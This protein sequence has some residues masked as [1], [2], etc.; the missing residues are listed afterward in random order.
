M[1]GQDKQREAIS[2]L[3]FRIRED[4]KSDNIIKS[5]EIICPECKENIFIELKDFKINLT[6]CKNGHI[7]NN[8]SFEDY[9]NVQVLDISTIKCDSCKI[10]NKGIIHNYEF[11]KCISC[12]INLCPDCKRKHDQHHKI[13]DYDKKNY[14]CNIHKKNFVNYC[15]NCKENIC[16]SCEPSHK[17]HKLIYF[18]HILPDDNMMNK[19]DELKENIDSINMIIDDFI[20]KM[21]NVKKSFEIYYNTFSNLIHIYNNN[22]NCNYQLIKNINEFINNNKN[23]IDNI[24][25]IKHSVINEEPAKLMKIY[26]KMNKSK[27]NILNNVNNNIRIIDVNDEKYNL[28]PNLES[29]FNIVIDNGSSSIKFGITG[30]NIFSKISTCI[31][32]SNNNNDNLDDNHFE[33]YIGE[34]MEIT[35]EH[36]SLNYP[37]DRG[38]IKYWNILEKLYDHIFYNELKVNTSEHNILITELPFNSNKNRENLT[39]FMFEVYDVPGFYIMNQ[40]ALSLLAEGKSTGLVVDLGDSYNHIYPM[41]NYGCDKN[42]KWTKT[43]GKDITEFL[44]KSLK[45]NNQNIKYL[46][47]AK[48]IKEKCC[49]VAY[50]YDEEI[51]SVESDE[52]K[53]PDSTSITIK[54]L[55]IKCPELLFTSDVNDNDNIAKICNDIIQSSKEDMRRDLYKTIIL[56]GGNSMFPGLKERLTKEIKN[57]APYDYQEDIKV[58][59]SPERIYHSQIGGQILASISTFERKWI[60]KLEYEEEGKGIIHKKCPNI[61]NSF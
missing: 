36:L 8:L 38:I 16:L 60:T 58:L 61:P 11:Y 13:I 3:V 32:Y 52:Y 12:K 43:G 57:F 5:K 18:G 30:E 6:G 46:E 53:L 26:Y 59:A 4:M 24:N 47:H 33:Y 19:L 50:D 37:I 54:D 40:S 39:E 56:A 42:V 15:E 29:E 49:Y 34:K 21:E 55:R 2:I 1:N 22:E 9:E 31:G 10:R 48:M 20:K 14:I 35:R 51:K 45:E 28:N 41:I 25:K 7:I 17:D 27:N 23:I 44:F